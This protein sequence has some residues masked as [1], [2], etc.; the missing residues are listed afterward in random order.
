MFRK[1]A[2][3]L[4]G[5]ICECEQQDLSWRFEAASLEEDKTKHDLVIQCRSCDESIA[6]PRETFVAAV[7]LDVPYPKGIVA[8]K[9]KSKA[10]VV[11][12]PLPVPEKKEPMESNVVSFLAFFRRMKKKEKDKDPGTDGTKPPA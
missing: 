8:K 3:H 2:I 4:K 1:F 5:P 6:V 7:V 9:P 11:A 10:V 12:D